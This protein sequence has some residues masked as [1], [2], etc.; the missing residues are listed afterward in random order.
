[1]SFVD[2][3]CRSE[4]NFLEKSSIKNF[5]SASKIARKEV[6]VDLFLKDRASVK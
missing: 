4:E 1:M 3:Q 2:V 6:L 5:S